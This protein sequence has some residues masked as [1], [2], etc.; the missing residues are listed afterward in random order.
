[1]LVYKAPHLLYKQPFDNLICISFP[2][3]KERKS[4]FTRYYAKG[5]LRWM[6][7]K[8]SMIRVG[9]GLT[10]REHTSRKLLECT[11][12]IS[13][14]TPMIG[15]VQVQANNLIATPRLWWQIS[16]SDVDMVT[17]HPSNWTVFRDVR[18]SCALNRL[19]HDNQL[20][21]RL[22]GKLIKTAGL[23]LS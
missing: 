16:C 5:C 21:K 9:P 20:K 6:V 3:G 14:V 23:T 2:E 4:H 7:F 15:L 19:E 10:S 1:M 13:L 18:S 17:S 12:H 11:K 22:R 8:A